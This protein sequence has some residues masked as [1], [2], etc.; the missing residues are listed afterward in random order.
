MLQSDTDAPTLAD[1]VTAKLRQAILDGTRRPGHRLTE[2]ALAQEMQTSRTPVVTALKTLT[3]QGLVEYAQ[4]RGYWVR[5]LE[6]Q[7]VIAAYE[8][9][10]TLE[11]LACRRAAERGVGR[12]AMNRLRA[13]LETGA[14]LTSGAGLDERDHRPYQEMNARF[15]NI[16]LSASGNPRLGDF[17][18]KCHELPLA[19]DRIVFWRSLDIVRRSQADHERIVD[20]IDQRHGTRA[21]MLMREHVHE[22]GAVLWRHWDEVYPRSD[23]TGKE[24]RP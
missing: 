11:G 5:K 18:R 16:L 7:D 23:E 10:A 2:T 21:E 9:R 17:V 24:L 3:E 1:A 4:N 14:A 19:S 15:H 22:A 12:D 13:C 20:A 8:I 6:V